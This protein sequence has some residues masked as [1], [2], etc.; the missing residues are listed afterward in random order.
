MVKNKKVGAK[1]L[2]AMRKGTRDMKKYMDQSQQRVEENH[3]E[4]GEANDAFE[5]HIRE[6]EEDTE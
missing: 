5:E 1:P 4:D 6:A 2:S 3:T